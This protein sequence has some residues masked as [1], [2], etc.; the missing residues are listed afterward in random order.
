MGVWAGFCLLLGPLVGRVDGVP[1]KNRGPVAV[2]PVPKGIPLNDRYRVWVREPGGTWQELPILNVKVGHQEG[3]DPLRLSVDP[4][5]YRGPTNASLVLFDFDQTVEIRI[6]Y[7]PQELKGYHLSPVSY[8]IKPKTVGKDMVEFTLTQN[9]EAPRKLV[10]RPNGEWES[11]SLHLLTNPLESDIP[12]P[13]A[14]DVLS[15]K[16]GDPIPLVLPE[17]KKTF[18][19]L[20]GI[21]ELPRGLWV[22]LDLGEIRKIGSFDLLTGPKAKWVMP[23]G[24]RF[25]IETRV[26]KEGPWQ[27]A[28]ERL[29]DE[30]ALD[31]RNVKLHG[32]EARFVRLTLLGN[33]NTARVRDYNYPN[34]AQIQQFTLYDEGGQKVS[35]GKAV[36]GALSNYSSVTDDLG[37]ERYGSVHGRETY[38]IPRSDVRLYLAP[39]AVV[40]G[41]LAGYGLRNIR[42][43]GRGILDAGDLIRVHALAEGKTSP[44]RMENGSNLAVEGIT[45]QDAPM[46][47]VILN[48][49][50]GVRVQHVNIL[51]SVCNGD[52][53]HFSGSQNAE[54]SGCFIRVPDDLF[55]LYH[56][57]DTENIRFRNCVLWSD[58]GRIALFGMGS[59]GNIRKVTVEN[60]DV[61]AHQSVWDA[62]I[63]G[64]IF[65]IFPNHGRTIEEVTF[66]DIRIEAVRYPS[67]SGLFQLK[68]VPLGNRL[69]GIIRKVRFENI[70][71]PF[72]GELP[73]YLLSPGEANPVEDVTFK[74]IRWGKEMLSSKNAPSFIVMSNMAPLRFE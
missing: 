73:S 52:G 2:H 60:C 45:I 44:I 24:L 31:M 7:T 27:V 30:N 11:E 41:S 18:Y 21:H 49:S 15:L 61:L 62:K 22:D 56:Y 63:H 25:R 38:F 1:T 19:F 65:Q 48:K 14:K 4:R 33:H 17:G 12:D 26:S 59:Q 67:I 69:P 34:S 43:D 64:N 72:P 29:E 8:G 3:D 66:K 71:Y 16:P 5:P 35:V 23:G 55:V 39:G 40:R 53:I 13:G 10:F 68:T 54:A 50:R 36:A 20:P 46:W 70:D 57:G 9:R 6:Q 42:I 37:S 74:N 58:G 32:T 47:S 28:H 51:N